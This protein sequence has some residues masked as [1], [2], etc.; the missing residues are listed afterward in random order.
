[1]RLKLQVLIYYVQKAFRA[2][3]ALIPSLA[4]GLMA[5]FA[6]AVVPISLW[7]K[8]SRHRN[9]PSADVPIIFFSLVFGVI[10]ALVVF[11]G[12]AR[13]LWPRREKDQQG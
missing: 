12:C 4:A 6:G 3:N 11:A 1:M 5:F 13:W 10:L 7:E 2:S 9:E 8:F